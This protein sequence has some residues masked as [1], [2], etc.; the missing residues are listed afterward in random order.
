[1]REDVAPGSV[2]VAP[3]LAEYVTPDSVEVAP[4]SVGAAP[5]LVEDVAPGSVEVVPDL[6]E[7]ASGSI[8]DVAPDSKE[9]VRL[10]PALNSV[11][12]SAG[13]LLLTDCQ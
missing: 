3:S 2:G 10:N 8:E 4:G 1:M 5:G 9:D 7:V 11:G 13:D 6:V 12:V